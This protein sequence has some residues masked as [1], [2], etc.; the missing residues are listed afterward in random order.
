[1]KIPGFTVD[2]EAVAAGLYQ[3]CREHK[4]GGC[5]ALGMLPAEIMDSFERMLAEKIPDRFFVNGE[6]IDGKKLRA[7]AV[8]A[9]TVAILKR[10]TNDGVCQV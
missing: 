7:E 3:M 10:A 4:N 8:H 6:R 1:M 2:I 5:M 9:I